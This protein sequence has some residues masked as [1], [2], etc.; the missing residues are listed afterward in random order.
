VG[1]FH[2]AFIDAEDIHALHSNFDNKKLPATFFWL[3]GA[4][5]IKLSH[6][7]I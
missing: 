1:L 3:P 4:E 2:A 7:P 6:H 5:I